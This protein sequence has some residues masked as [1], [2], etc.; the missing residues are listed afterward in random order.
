MFPRERVDDR[1]LEPS[2][3]QHP[4]ITCA[5]R[6]RG[7]IAV[8]VRD[9]LLQKDWRCRPYLRRGRRVDRRQFKDG[10][11]SQLRS[12]FIF[13]TARCFAAASA[14]R[15]FSAR[16][17]APAASSSRRKLGFSRPLANSTYGDTTPPAA[18]IDSKGDM[19]SRRA[20]LAGNRLVRARPGHRQA[21]ATVEDVRQPGKGRGMAE[22]ES[23]QEGRVHRREHRGTFRPLA[24]QPTPPLRIREALGLDPLLVFVGDLEASPS[25]VGFDPGGEGDQ[26]SAANPHRLEGGEGLQAVVASADRRPPGRCSALRCR[27][28]GYRAAQH[29]A[30]RVPDVAVSSTAR[31]WPLDDVRRFLEATKE[32]GSIAILQDRPLMTPAASSTSFSGT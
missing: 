9:G 10:D 31:V 6:T 13:S 7:V 3:G 4:S 24:D 18:T 19:P 27:R 11:R 14:S 20:R 1:D 2:I 12:L 32:F 5:M 30:W 8:E 16:C 29:L 21:S 28:D 23:G 25:L 26:L 17:F 22:R 15:F